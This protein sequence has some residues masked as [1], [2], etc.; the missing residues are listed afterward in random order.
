MH[1]HFSTD[2][3]TGQ[4]RPEAEQAIYQRIEMCCALAMFY[5]SQVCLLMLHNLQSLLLAALRLIEGHCNILVADLSI[6]SQNHFS[7]IR[8]NLSLIVLVHVSDR[9]CTYS[10]QKISEVLP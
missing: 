1:E 10:H 9:Y 6:G 5:T 2:R 4:P 8:S 3:E 7:G